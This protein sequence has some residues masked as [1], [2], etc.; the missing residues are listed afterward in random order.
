MA[1]RSTS[2]RRSRSSGKCS[3]CEGRGVAARAEA[4]GR[5][6]RQRGGRRGMGAARSAGAGGI[7]TGGERCARKVEGGVG[8]GMRRSA[9]A[10]RASGKRLGAGLA[11][12]SRAV[13][14]APRTYAHAPASSP[15][16]SSPTPAASPSP[17]PGRRPQG[18]RG[19]PD[20][21]QLA[22]QRRAC[23]VHR[24]CRGRAS[25]RRLRGH[26]ARRR[27]GDVWGGRRHGGA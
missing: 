22:R 5:A 16:P 15:A 25:A 21:R 14:L 27:C 18:S 6:E 26:G 20:G 7:R 11:E 24:F 13:R 9:R 3:R 2:A 1:L 17:R 12:G 8:E 4:Q 19:V 23:A 10:A